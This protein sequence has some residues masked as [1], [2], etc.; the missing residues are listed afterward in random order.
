MRVTKWLVVLP[1]LLLW[2]CNN[3]L[4]LENYNKISMGMSYNDVTTLIG[5]PE[6]CDDL[7][8]I[9]TCHWAN[10]KSTVSVSFAA[11]KTLLFSAENLH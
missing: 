9:R 2:G 4:S 1:M 8:G 7:M 3:K 10:D 11:D 6:K 5:K